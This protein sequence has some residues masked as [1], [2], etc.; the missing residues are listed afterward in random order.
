MSKKL[1]KFSPVEWELIT[2]RP[3]DCIADCIADDPES[4]IET[5]SW[6]KISSR[7]YDLFFRNEVRTVDL[8]N[9]MDRQI[10]RDAIVGGIIIEHFEDEVYHYGYHDPDDP[11]TSGITRY[12]IKRYR[13]AAKGIEKKT[14]FTYY[15]T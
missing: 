8:G 1:I 6:D 15:G 5:W 7:A 14:G 10:I 2:D 3:V 4:N 13:K 11:S 9:K 12:A